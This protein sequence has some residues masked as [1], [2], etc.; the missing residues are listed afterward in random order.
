[1]AHA[2]AT[3]V[4]VLMDYQFLSHFNPLYERGSREMGWS[5]N[6]LSVPKSLQRGICECIWSSGKS[7]NGLSV[8]K[9]LQLYLSF[10]WKVCKECLNGLSVP[11]SLQLG[12]YFVE[13]NCQQSLNGL[14]VPKSLQPISMWWGNNVH[15]LMDYQF[16]SHFNRP[17][18]GMY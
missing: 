5:L 3:G 17:K 11:K 9:S 18:T 12:V 7:L 2:S 16:L 1:M 6:G 4:Y 8:P 15:V 13:D 10:G 14:S